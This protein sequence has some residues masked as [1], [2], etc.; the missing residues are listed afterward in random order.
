MKSLTVSFLVFFSAMQCFPVKGQVNESDSLALV[1][2]YNATNG[3]SW[4][5][6]SG[7]LV[8]PVN[9]WY[10][11]TVVS[12]R[13][14]QILLGDIDN[15]PPQIGNNLNGTI[16][17]VLGTLDQL[18]Y[19]TLAGNNLSGPIPP[20][21]GNL[22][23][24]E[25]L[26]LYANNLSGTIPTELGNLVKIEQLYV[27]DNQLTGVIPPSLGN[28]SNLE[29]LSLAKN[30]LTGQIPTQLGQLSGLLHLWLYENDLTGSI[31]A[32]LGDLK[33]LQELQLHLNKLTGSIPP[34]LGS[35]SGLTHIFF[36]DNQ[37]TGQIPTTLGN[38]PQLFA[39]ELQGNQLTG[40]IPTSLGQLTSLHFIY[41]ARNQ[42]SGTIPSELGNLTNLEHLVVHLN[43]LTGEIPSTIGNL[44]NLTRLDLAA[45]QL[46]GPV[47]PVIGNL[48]NLT[49]LDLAP[50]NLTGSIPPE[51]GNLVKLETLWLNNNAFIGGI[52]AAVANFNN[53]STFYLS[54][55]ELEALPDLSGLPLNILDTRDNYFTFEDLEPHIGIANFQYAPQKNI[56]GGRTR[57]IAPGQ[58]F[59]A[60]FIVG[61]SANQYQWLKDGNPLPGTNSSTFTISAVT[62]ADAGNYTL[63]ATSSLVPGLT[64]ISEPVVLIVSAGMPEMEVK[65]DGTAQ[66]DG[67]TLAFPNVA[68]GTEEIR[69]LVITNTGDAP[70]VIDDLIVTG[71]YILQDNI[72]PPIDP[73]TSVTVN[74]GFSPEHTGKRVGTLTILSNGSVPSFVINL[75]GEGTIDLVV[76]NVVTPRQNDKYDYLEIG[77][78]TWF[79]ENRVSIYDRWGNKIFDQ[80]GYDNSQVTFSGTADNGNEMPEGTY[81]YVID[82]GNGDKRV[83]GFFLLRR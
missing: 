79:P 12:N 23:N 51:L 54:S 6:N 76:Y 37:L 75:E 45:N 29:I 28:L 40:P 57:V 65:K 43:Q 82:K 66:V 39:L 55:N 42:L 60:S 32:S 68:I 34:E 77:N 56:R 8:D 5:N 19:L 26:F 62:E 21:L 31:P 20:E 70:L 72:P 22:A 47:P 80:V 67:A 61:G 7:W 10:G 25:H 44:T 64:L 81:Y 53:L 3:A 52:P 15:A 71:D 59:D 33:Q 18:Q 27:D 38:L 14:V 16:P 69:Q 24:L 2:L 41:L 11:I 74:I 50:N 46:S 73:G 35:S 78:I 4:V 17:P 30:N 36:G 58:P 63:R 49:Y 13:V 83:T 9:T 48:I 1:A